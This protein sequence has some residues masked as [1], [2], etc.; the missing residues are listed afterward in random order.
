M[1]LLA[2][3]PDENAP[4]A[5]ANLLARLEGGK[6]LEHLGITA[7][8]DSDMGRV[9]KLKSLRILQVDKQ[10]VPM[11]DLSPPRKAEINKLLVKATKLKLVN[12]IP[13]DESL[14]NP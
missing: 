11:K 6:Q 13:R 12:R 2:G 5:A 9:Q 4:S 10:E 3:T 8:P 7:L 1:G 14:A